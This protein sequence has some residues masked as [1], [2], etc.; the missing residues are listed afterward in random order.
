MLNDDNDFNDD[1]DND[2]NDLD[3]DGFDD[4]GDAD[5]GDDNDGFDDDGDDNWGDDGDGDWDGDE[6][7]EEGTIPISVN[8]PDILIKQQSVCELDEAKIM[9]AQDTYIENLSEEL[10]LDKKKCLLLL[11][12]FKWNSDRIIE[13]YFDNPKKI[14][15]D[16][17]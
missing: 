17:G 8:Q 15:Y 13:Q 7:V 11:R 5:F 16:A 14:L 6:V 12:K 2:M 3:N 4:D 1:N 9:D 10:N